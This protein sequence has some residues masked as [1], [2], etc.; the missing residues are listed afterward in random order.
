MNIVKKKG[1]NKK[2]SK[3]PMLAKNVIA[4]AIRRLLSVI[5]DYKLLLDLSVLVSEQ[6]LLEAILDVVYATMMKKSTGELIKNL[7]D[8]N[9]RCSISFINL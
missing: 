6:L 9:K 4:Q 2:S 1:K 3:Q 5:V 7:F 8:C